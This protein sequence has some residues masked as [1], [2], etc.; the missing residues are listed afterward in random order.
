MSCAAEAE[1]ERLEV[2]DLLLVIGGQLGS[3]VGARTA[4]AQSV[5]SLPPGQRLA[6]GREQG[7]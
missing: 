1:A 7:G 4:P 2:A 3:T 5:V 6:S